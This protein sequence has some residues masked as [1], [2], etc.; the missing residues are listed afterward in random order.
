M[1]GVSSR[2]CFLHLPWAIAEGASCNVVQANQP[3]A[4]ET[5]SIASA[6][7]N[8]LYIVVLQTRLEAMDTVV[9]KTQEPDAASYASVL[10]QCMAHLPGFEDKNFQVGSWKPCTHRTPTGCYTQSQLAGQAVCGYLM[11]CVLLELACSSL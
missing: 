5:C 7:G 11:Q 8:V 10:T 3:L 6:S 9:A 2:L 4:H 1:E